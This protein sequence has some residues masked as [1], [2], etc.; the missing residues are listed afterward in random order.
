[1]SHTTAKK[2]ENEKKARE[3]GKYSSTEI[4]K[5]SELLEINIAGIWNSK[6]KEQNLDDQKYAILQFV[7]GLLY[8]LCILFDIMSLPLCIR[9]LSLPSIPPLHWS[10]QL[11]TSWFSVT[12]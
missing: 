2:I 8:L 10:L 11:V 9:P 3:H 1:M 5:L 7:F 6:V 12:Y 4:F